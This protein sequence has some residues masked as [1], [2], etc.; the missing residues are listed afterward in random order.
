MSALLDAFRSGFDALPAALREAG[1][2]GAA[3]RAA[4]DAALADGLP[5]A[6][7]ERWKYTSLRALERRAFAPSADTASVDPAVLAHIP[8]PRLVFVNGRFD[9]G[10]SRSQ[11]LP[12]GLILRPLSAQLAAGDARAVN[13]L[14]RR[15]EAA[16]DTFPRL[17]AALATEGALLR[18]E[19]GL[20]IEP[21]VH[22]VFI[23]T[24]AE[25]DQAWHLR[26]L[27]ELREGAELTVVEHHLA[28]GEHAHLINALCHVHLKPAARLTHLRLQDESGT[29]TSLLRTDAA[30]AGEAEYRRFDLELGAALSRHELNVSLQG[31]GARLLANGVLLADGRRHL[32]TR[33][34]IDHAAPQTD[35]ELTWRGL[36]NER[37][38]AVFH[39]GI[40]IRAGADGSSAALANKN[41]LLSE[42]AEIDTQPV[43]VIHADEVQAAHGATVGRLDPQALFYLRS[44]GLPLE[45][46]RALLT[47]A[48]CR[49]PLQAVASGDL[50]E[51]V[52]KRLDAAL[53][54][55]EARA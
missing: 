28:A 38:R 52:A 36:A 51:G 11:T 44:R 19:A 33:L 7:A 50:A 29:A 46:A 9:A 10:L 30:L 12:D 54:R 35:C 18:V 45:A 21:P 17:N 39:G 16:D 4:L 22:L 53:A 48:F 24:G 6:R 26:H 40:E 32:D 5:K 14:A 15:F 34:G 55:G 47:A 13:F 49:E 43:L 42:G 8:A 25:A 1:D 27:I 2:L 3:R 41:L 20:R 37:G 23:G 31:R